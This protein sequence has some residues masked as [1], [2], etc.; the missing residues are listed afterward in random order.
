MTWNY[1]IVRHADG[2]GF[3]LHEVYYNEAGEE[4]RMTVEP[5]TFF[6]DTAEGVREALILAK[7]EATRRPVFDEPQDWS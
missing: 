3:G 6:S 2:S 1:R 4:L 7:M 5:V